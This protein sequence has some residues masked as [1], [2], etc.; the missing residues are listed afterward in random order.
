MK[1][2]V[3]IGLFVLAGCTTPNPQAFT[4]PSGKTA[5]SFECAGGF[6]D[7]YKTAG[8]V[9]PGGYDIIDQSS[10]PIGANGI[11]SSREQMAVECR[12]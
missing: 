3:L 6:S 5:Y 1:K 12:N 2:L 10:R 7:C 9:C 4:G 8:T 11:I